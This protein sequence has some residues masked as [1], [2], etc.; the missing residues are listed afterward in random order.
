M[1]TPVAGSTLT[2]EN[3]HM[4]T[5]K[6]T[7]TDV[8]GMTVDV[9]AGTVWFGTNPVEFDGST[10]PTITA[11]GSNANWFFVCLRN[12]SDLVILEG[13][14]GATPTEPNV[15]DNTLPL[16][17]IYVNSTDVAITKDM[18]N[19]IRPVFT[20][21]EVDSSG[22]PPHASDHITAGTDAMQSATALQDGLMTQA[23]AAKLDGIE[24]AAT[25]DM[26]GAEIKTAY[27][28]EGDT[29]AYT[30]AAVTKLAGIETDATADMT[31]AEI[32]TAYEAETNAFT[33]ALYT[34]LDGVET[35][36]TADMTGAEIKTAYEAEGDTNAFTDAESTKLA[37]IDDGATDFEIGTISRAGSEPTLSSDGDM[38]IWINTSDSSRTYL[39]YRRGVGDQVKVELT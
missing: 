19:D 14:A 13:T 15:P 37:G 6:V 3:G 20:F 25:V 17:A 16:A 30:D 28:A 33:D 27:E 24:D 32:K 5:L 11:P 31:G 26:T 9:S 10:S 21:P 1:D 2:R 23:Y 35:D 39:V 4:S 22:A 7:P 29:N 34:K 8:P 36:A 38:T 18:I 12:I